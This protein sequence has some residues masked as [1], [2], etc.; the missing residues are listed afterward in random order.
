MPCCT[1]EELAGLFDGILKR[2]TARKLREHLAGC[3][4]CAHELQELDRAL[5]GLQP[6][7]LPDAVMAR[8]LSREPT[9]AALPRR[10]GTRNKALNTSRIRASST[11]RP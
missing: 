4:H 7:P 10:T 3:P 1:A 11:H 9:R 5:R 8:A 2:S 6:K